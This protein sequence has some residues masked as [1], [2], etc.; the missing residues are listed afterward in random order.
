MRLRSSSLQWVLKWILKKNIRK[1]IDIYVLCKYRCCCYFVMRALE[2]LTWPTFHV[3]LS[4]QHCIVYAESFDVL[5]LTTKSNTRTFGSLSP[6][7]IVWSTM[8]ENNDGLICLFVYL[9]T[10]F[11]TGID[12]KKETKVKL[13]N[14][15]FIQKTNFTIR[16]YNRYENQN[17]ILIFFCPD[18]S[19]LITEQ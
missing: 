10:Q 8:E 12:L 4:A 2:R 14:K 3:Q 15:Y 6:K 11:A 16:T 5:N 13:N 9:F 18:L 17:T 1:T 19:S 7:C